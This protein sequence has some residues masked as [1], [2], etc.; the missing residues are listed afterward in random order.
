MGIGCGRELGGAE[1]Q[2]GPLLLDSGA[3]PVVLGVLTRSTFIGSE[4]TQGSLVYFAR[5]RDEAWVRTVIPSEP[6]NQ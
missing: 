6:V 3:G 5:L 1:C 2:G 4:V